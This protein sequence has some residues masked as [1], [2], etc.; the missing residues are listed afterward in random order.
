M[1]FLHRRHLPLWT[2][3][4]EASEEAKELSTT[5]RTT[6]IFGR[7]G[8]GWV[9]WNYRRIFH[10]MVEKVGNDNESHYNEQ[11]NELYGS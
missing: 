5:L 11:W 9:I 6:I 2:T 1:Y 8:D 10:D 7:W 4:A 3:F